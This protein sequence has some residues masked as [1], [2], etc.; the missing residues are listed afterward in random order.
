MKRR[1]INARASVAFLFEKGSQNQPLLIYLRGAGLVKLPAL[2]PPKSKKK[3]PK[4]R[5]N[6]FDVFQ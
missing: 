1:S 4:E 6:L 5:C 3:H 2:L